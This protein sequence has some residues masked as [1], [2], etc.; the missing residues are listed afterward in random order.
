MENKLLY[1]RYILTDK[2]YFKACF[3]KLC[4]FILEIWHIFANCDIDWTAY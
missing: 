4:V 2:T 3:T 1:N